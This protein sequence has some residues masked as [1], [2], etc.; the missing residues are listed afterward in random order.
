MCKK[1]LAAA[2]MSVGMLSVANVQA[3]A[4]DPG[5]FMVRA[6]AV[7]LGWENGQ[8]GGLP[9]GGD[10]KVTAQNLWIPEIDLTYFF[11]KNIATELVLTYPQDINVNVGGSKAGTISALPPSLMLQYHFT[12]LGAFKPYVGVGV[13]YTLF[14]KRDN[15]LGGAASVSNSSVGVVGQL[16]FDYMIDKN[17]GV[18]VDLKYI[19]MATNV[20]VGGDKAGTLNLNPLSVGLGVSYRF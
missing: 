7:Y 20:Y 9:L 18:N 19:Q 3:Q 4:A 2:L 14:Y 12:D 1:V 8:G 17:W 16:G 15:I 13:N 10:T 5:P 11:T 6:R